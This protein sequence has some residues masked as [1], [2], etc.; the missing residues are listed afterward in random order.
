M[1]VVSEAVSAVAVERD[2]VGK[3]TDGLNE[4]ADCCAARRAADADWFGML[5]DFGEEEKN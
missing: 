2:I 4:P 3:E 1:V 5:L